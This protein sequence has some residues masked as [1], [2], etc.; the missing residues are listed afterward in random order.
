MCT[1]I[2]MHHCPPPILDA[3]S[4]KPSFNFKH[5][6][7]FILK[8]EIWL[9]AWSPKLKLWTSNNLFSYWIHKQH[10]TIA[11]HWQPFWHPISTFFTVAKPRGV[12][13]KQTRWNLYFHRSQL[14]LHCRRNHIIPKCVAPR[15]TKGASYAQH[16]ECTNKT[17]I[18]SK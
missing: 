16:V 3:I 9:V 5:P 11:M 13:C 7:Q 2:F 17:E 12:I 4:S 14:L 18:Q 10:P 8:C 1:G 6:A 15:N